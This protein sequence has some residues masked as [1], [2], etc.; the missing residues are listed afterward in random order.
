MD[1]RRSRQT[2]VSRRSRPYAIRREPLPRHHS[3][4]R[5][6]LHIRRYS[7]SPAA[8]AK[9]CRASRSLA[10]FDYSARSSR[11]GPRLR[12][13]RRGN[14]RDQASHFEPRCTRRVLSDQ[15]SGVILFSSAGDYAKAVNYFS[16]SRF[17]ELPY[18]ARRRSKS[19]SGCLLVKLS[20]TSDVPCLRNGHDTGA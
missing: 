16:I 14:P 18:G 1:I 20:R 5:S 13:P 3:L 12:F 4:V 2:T 7:S 11:R 17:T 19:M 10:I 9:A 8:W 6:P 15:A